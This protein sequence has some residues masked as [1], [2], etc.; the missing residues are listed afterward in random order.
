MLLC[1]TPFAEVIDRRSVATPV[2]AA[3]TSARRR[4]GTST[5][6]AESPRG[7]CDT[8]RVAADGT[9]TGDTEVLRA[10]V[11]LLST[12]DTSLSVDPAVLS[13]DATLLTDEVAITRRLTTARVATGN[14]RLGLATPI[15]DWLWG[16]DEL[17]FTTSVGTPAGCGAI[18]DIRRRIGSAYVAVGAVTAGD[19]DVVA[20]AVARAATRSC[21]GRDR[22]ATI[23]SAVAG[24]ATALNDG[25]EPV[26]VDDVDRRTAVGD[27]PSTVDE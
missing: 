6:G 12:D 16:V 7:R 14:D 10:A 26:P 2:G 27:S 3:A 23:W 18:A 4:T 25:A 21:S 11:P 5:I 9:A 24:G 15:N 13:G 8:M 19:D 17:P 22:S 20:G 1:R